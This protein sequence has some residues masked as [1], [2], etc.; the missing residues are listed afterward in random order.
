LAVFQALFT[1]FSAHQHKISY[2]VKLNIIDF[3][4]IDEQ[5]WK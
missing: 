1:H 4:L 5:N 3:V 2:K